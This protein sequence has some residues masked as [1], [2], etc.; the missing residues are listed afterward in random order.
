MG[1]TFIFTVTTGRS[2]TSYLTRL[3]A[4]NLIDAEVHHERLGYQAFG[5]DTPDASHFTLFNSLGNVAKVKNFWRG[6]LARVAQTPADLYAEV[7][8]FNAKAGLIENLDVLREHG[9][10]HIILLRRDPL[11][12]LRS[13]HNRHDFANLGF[14]WLF[15]LDPRYPNKIVERRRRDAAG[16]AYW[17]IQEMTARSA[18]YHRLIADMP[19]VFAHACD[20]AEIATEAGAR[21]LLQGLD[22]AT[23]PELA[24]P[25][26]ENTTQSWQLAET[27]EDLLAELVQKYDTDCSALGEA[28]YDSG[29]RLSEPRSQRKQTR[30]V[31]ISRAGAHPEKNNVR[32]SPIPLF[33][34]SAGQLPL[35]EIMADQDR[36][37]VAVL[38]QLGASLYYAG[39]E[40][41]ALERLTAAYEI[42][43][44]FGAIRATLATIYA[45]RGDADE[46]LRYAR[47]AVNA[48]ADDVQ[49]WLAIGKAHSIRNQPDQAVD[50]LESALAIDESNVYTLTALNKNCFDAGR[51]DQA[52]KFGEQALVTRDVDS[53]KAFPE[54]SARFDLR[55][56]AP[57]PPTPSRNVIAFALWGDNPVY[58]E[59]MVEN[60][61]LAQEHYAGWE[62]RLY[63]D[64]SVAPQLIERLAQLDVACIRVDVAQERLMGT[65]WRFLASD[66]PTVGR[67]VCRDADARIGGRERAAV[68]AWERSEMPFHVMRDHPNHI[69]LMLAGLWGGTAGILPALEP[70]AMALY[71][72]QAYR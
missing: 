50:A 49:A 38:E 42:D 48:K 46:A 66:D 3:L 20:L 29:R 32:P 8:H 5:V 15:A 54:L 39:D 11:A 67:F 34:G 52:L 57:T 21:V 19:G 68:A 41:G 72:D 64:G 2:G 36:P 31:V 1:K 53:F 47:E 61:A 13:F 40:E 7:S 65:F 25:A 43:P 9:D 59:G 51:L 58:T 10:V 26:P 28:F 60:A 69:E 33:G 16:A 6:K 12:T 30:T 63:H 14:T 4:E 23:K 18:Y 55:L 17:Y 24:V 71:A 62:C 35:L 27:D 44:A 56:S 37:S 22:V 70:F 45:R